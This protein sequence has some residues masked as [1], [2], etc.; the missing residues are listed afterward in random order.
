MN[1]KTKEKYIKKW[2]TLNAYEETL[3]KTCSDCQ[4]RLVST[5]FYLKR[6]VIDGLDNRCKRCSRTF[7]KKCR[8]DSPEWFMLYSARQRAR[9]KDWEF[10]LTIEDIQI[11]ESCPVLG[12]ILCRGDGKLTPTSPT[13]DRIDSSKGYIKGNV[14]VISHRANTIKSNA[15]VKELELVLKDARAC[16]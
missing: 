5:E 11:P 2:Q 10:N 16:V 3:A 8:I 1:N 13:L 15:T 14:R 6:S 4:L 12:I 7:A 9:A